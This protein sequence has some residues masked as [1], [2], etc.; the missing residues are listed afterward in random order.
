[1]KRKP[2]TVAD[3]R[4]LIQKLGR[5]QSLGPYRADDR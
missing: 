4:K 1:M 5:R 3:A 2:I